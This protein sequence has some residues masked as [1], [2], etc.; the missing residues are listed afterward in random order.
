MSS[1]EAVMV[2]VEIHHLEAIELGRDFCDLV[3]L[4][5]LLEFDAFC[6]PMEVSVLV[7]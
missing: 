4:T 1:S 7:K 6:I 5:L 3:L 2:L